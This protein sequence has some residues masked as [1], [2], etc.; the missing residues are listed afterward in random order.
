MLR[1]IE[2]TRALFIAG[3]DVNKTYEEESHKERR[4]LELAI[5]MKGRC[6]PVDMQLI[7]MLLDGGTEV[8]VVRL[9]C[10]GEIRH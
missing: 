7:N 6:S 1:S 8:R 2:V 3:A 9:P 5:R 4:A 10:A